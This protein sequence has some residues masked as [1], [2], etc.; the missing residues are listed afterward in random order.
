MTE[1]MKDEM[2]AQIK[3][4][5][6]SMNS[7]IVHNNLFWDIHNTIKMFESKGC[8]CDIYIQ[9]KQENTW[10][11]PQQLMLTKKD[12]VPSCSNKH[13][14]IVLDNECFIINVSDIQEVCIKAH[15]M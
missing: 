1:Q 4:E 2:M 9:L 14:N 11:T 3:D 6:C 10:K 7:E 15:K 5:L 12:I 13:L 8:V